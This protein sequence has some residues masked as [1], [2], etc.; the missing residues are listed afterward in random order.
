MFMD[1]RKKHSNCS[2][3]T[4]TE[5]ILKFFTLSVPWSPRV[6]YQKSPCCV[7]CAASLNRGLERYLSRIVKQERCEVKT[8]LGILT[9]LIKGSKRELLGLENSGG[10]QVFEEKS[11]LL[12]EAKLCSLAYTGLRQTQI[13]LSFGLLKGR[14]SPRHLNAAVPQDDGF[15][16]SFLNQSVLRLNL[17]RIQPRRWTLTG[18]WG[19][20]I[21]T[22]K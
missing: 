16:F 18:R 1:S 6:E 9:V 17:F 21:R 13:A 5:Q 3:G 15:I 11:I 7:L 2:V 8:Q 22:R 19:S 20:F 14:S 4:Q 12:L 10:Q